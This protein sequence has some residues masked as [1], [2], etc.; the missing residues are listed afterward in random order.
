MLLEGPC[1]HL[2]PVG[3][4]LDSWSCVGKELLLQHNH[5]KFPGQEF[6][7]GKHW[8]GISTPD[9]PRQTA[10]GTMQGGPGRWTSPG[11]VQAASTALQQLRGVQRL[12]PFG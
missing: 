8:Q 1:Q 10:V 5:E 7:Q 2:L 6:W 9:L 12:L 11:E 4:L 3:S